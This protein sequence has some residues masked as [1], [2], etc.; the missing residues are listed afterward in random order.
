MIEKRDLKR[1][2]LLIRKSLSSVEIFVKSW[3]AQENFLK[4][5][6]Y[7][8]GKTI[9]LYYPILNE[10]DTTW[11][12]K[13]SLIDNKTVCLPKLIDGKISFFSIAGLSDLVKG[14]YGIMEPPLNNNNLVNEIDIA[15]VPGLVFD[16]RGYRI[17]YGKGYYDKYFN[18]YDAGPLIGIGFCYDFQLLPSNIINV[19]PHDHRLSVIITNKEILL[20]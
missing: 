17:G 1:K 5:K 19:E 9:A 7:L 3:F 14:Q 20:I 15:I 16:R 4:S 6:F 2:F 8:D 18:Q 13:Q 11:I 10:V 12:I